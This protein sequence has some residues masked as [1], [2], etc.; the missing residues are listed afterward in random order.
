MNLDFVLACQHMEMVF[1]LDF[2]GIFWHGNSYNSAVV[3]KVVW[4]VWRCLSGG[5]SSLITLDSL[6][7]V[8]EYSLVHLCDC[9]PALPLSSGSLYLK[10]KCIGPLSSMIHADFHEQFLL[11]IP[12]Q[13][14]RQ[15]LQTD[16]SKTKTICMNRLWM[17]QIVGLKIHFNH[18]PCMDGFF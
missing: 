13:L 15:K 4:S 11:K 12:S 10:R 9:W 1:L 2:I 17:S 18:S 8:V 7:P 3:R 5:T 14:Q 6:S 16:T